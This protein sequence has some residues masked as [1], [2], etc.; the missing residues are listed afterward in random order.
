[1]RIGGAPVSALRVLLVLL[2]LSP[3]RG[4]ADVLH[5]LAL[6]SAIVDATSD[7]HLQD[8]LGRIAFYESNFTRSVADCRVKGDH[9]S[10]LGAFQV[11]PRSPVERRLL[12]GPLDG[13]VRIALARIEESLAWCGNLNGFTSGRCDRGSRK[14]RERWGSP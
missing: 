9:G 5:R 11:Q 14:A 8:V 12:C 7:E 6:A 10:A 1:M 4:D 13:Q 3:S 2:G